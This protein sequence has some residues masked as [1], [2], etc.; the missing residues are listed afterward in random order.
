[1]NLA[2]ELKT[3]VRLRTEPIGRAV[4]RLGISANAL[5]LL[6]LALNVA[7]AA[8]VAAGWLPAGGLVFLVASAFDAL[9]GAVAR[10]SGT[11]SPF[12]AFLDSLTDRY[13]EAV[14]FTPLLLLFAGQQQVGLVVACAGA[15]VG[16]LLVSYA[17]ARAE[18]L[19]V[20]CEIGLLQRPERVI[21]MAAGLIVP[22]LLLAPVIVLLAVVT[23]VTVLQRALHVRRL[24]A[25]SD[26][27]STS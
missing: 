10:A 22:D 9:D 14:I 18:G 8:L 15:L 19:G 25:G 13:A 11:A 2:A 3:A 27:G 20:D 26:Q 6:G 21:L 4:S 12:G 16:S 5:T 24:L 23:N 17:R 1:V 7:G